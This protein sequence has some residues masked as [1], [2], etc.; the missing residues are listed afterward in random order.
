M[1]KN[2]A[3]KLYVGVSKSPHDRVAYHNAKRGA[4]FTKHKSDYVI[5]FLEK[6]KTLTE[7]RL[8]EIQIKKWRRGKKEMLI[9]RYN[10]KLSTKQN[11]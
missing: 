6:Y 1:I 11:T 7:A 8:R 5:V 10:K 9:N 2:S 4:K 3:E